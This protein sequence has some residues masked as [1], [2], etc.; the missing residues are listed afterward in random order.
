M[1]SNSIRVQVKVLQR[2]RATYTPAAATAKLDL[3]ESLQNR[4]ISQP[5]LLKSLHE[6]LCFICAFPDSLTHHKL[7]RR[8]LD[9]F[10]ERIASLKAKTRETLADTGIEATHVYYRF[11]YEVAIWLAR[12]SPDTV[13]VDWPELEN[14]GRLD[15]ILRQIVLPGEYDYYTSG[16]V[17]ERQWIAR[18]KGA[19]GVTDFVWLLAQMGKQ[20]ATKRFWSDMYDAADLPLRW[21]VG[22]DFAK[23]R[24]TLVLG[25]PKARTRGMRKL[26]ESVVHTIARPLRQIQCL[27]RRQGKRAIRTA[28]AALA[29]RHRETYHFNHANPEEVYAADVG[30]GVK[31]VVYGLLPEHRFTLETTMGYLIVA[32]GMPIGY[33]GASAIF[34][35]AN[36]GI[37]VFDE[38]RGSEAAYLW[39]QVLR[40]FHHLFGC[41]YFVVNPYQIGA[42]NKEALRSGAFW[43]YYRLGFRPAVKAIARLASTENLKIKAKKGYRT[44]LR[45]LKRLTECDLYLSL[46]ET[47][48][49]DFFEEDW[50]E[51]CAAG[52]TEVLGRQQ[53]LARTAA[54]REAAIQLVQVLGQESY[55]HWSSLEQRALLLQAPLIGLL[56]DLSE[57]KKAERSQ[58]LKLIRAKGGKHERNYIRIMSKHDRLRQ[59]LS[60][61]CQNN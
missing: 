57:W 14:L 47:S 44:D 52:A 42:E 36:T 38:Y 56:P 11:S 2:F 4:A 23:G 25:S 33:G 46:D 22:P 15:E 51:A 50:L 12:H 39:V 19:H 27:T 8:G 48:K 29:V 16:Q 7:A 5:S 61:Y 9:G 54:A 53:S 32:N 30:E 1:G 18:A 28:M 24:N 35:Q 34:H 59:S 3:L 55:R 6:S 37:N 31:I 21:R 58:L 49:I 17:S 41:K 45:T 60:N 10:G 40:V 43:F 13:E 20:R 26:E